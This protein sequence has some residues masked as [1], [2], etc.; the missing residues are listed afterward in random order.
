MERALQILGQMS[1]GVEIFRAEAK[2]IT[3]YFTDL[4]YTEDDNGMPQVRGMLKLNDELGNNIDAYDILIE[5]TLGYPFK[6]PLVFEFGGRIPKNIDWHVFPMGHCC[7]KCPPEEILTCKKGITLKDFIESEL[8]PYFFNQ[9]H[10]ELTGFFLHERSHGL[11][12]KY[13]EFLKEVFKTDN[14][15]EIADSLIFIRKREEPN[16]VSKCFCGR[17]EKYRKCHRETFR[18]L[19]Q[20]NDEELM[21]CFKAVVSQAIT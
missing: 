20:F 11:K 18:L 19:S 5:Y 7:I 4:I 12:G 21:E 3:S 17:N 1:D 16:R 9:K 15:V 14:L 6:F 13:I 8:R 2:V 10:R